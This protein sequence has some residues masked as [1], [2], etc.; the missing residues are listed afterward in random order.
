ME[1][2]NKREL[3]EIKEKDYENP[4]RDA[5]MRRLKLFLTVIGIALVLLIALVFTLKAN[6]SLQARLEKQ[7]E[8]LQSANDKIAEIIKYVP[9]VDYNNES[10]IEEE[11]YIT[12][13]PEDDPTQFASR[14]TSY[15]TGDSTGSTKYTGSGIST[16]RFKVNDKGWYTYDGKIV[17]ATATNECLNSTKG[18]CG[19]YKWSDAVSHYFNYFDELTVTIDGK[20]YDGIVLDSCG[21][22]MGAN[23]DRIDLFVK[24]KDSVIDRG[25]LG[26][27][28]VIVQFKKDK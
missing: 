6:S 28:P 12:Q 23:G 1:F 2:F 11:G 25:Y 24:D 15:Y 7:D 18:A 8:Q 9:T 4:K 26:N 19:K 27:N 17:L 21:A 3:E 16:E 5:A 13:K 22:C 20:Q 10:T 14:M